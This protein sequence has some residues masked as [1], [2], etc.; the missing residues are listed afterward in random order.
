M[1]KQVDFDVRVVPLGNGSNGS[2]THEQVA[3][4]VR[5]YLRE[6]W[7]VFSDHVNQVSA[8]VIYYQI[9]LA[10]YEEDAL[11]PAKKSIDIKA[12]ADTPTPK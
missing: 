3:E 11:T 10:K 7:E 5:G 6:G 2:M 12:S 4:F 8:G 9:T 1:R